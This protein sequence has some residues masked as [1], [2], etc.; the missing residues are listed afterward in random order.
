MQNDHGPA[1]PQ[2][3]SLIQPFA[4]IPRLVRGIGL[5]FVAAAALW[6]ATPAV[7]PASAAEGFGE[8]VVESAA[9]QPADGN[10]EAAAINEQVRPSAIRKRAFWAHRCRGAANGGQRCHIEHA[11]LDPKH[12]QI[13]RFAVADVG[14]VRRLVVFAPVGLKFP[15]ASM[16]ASTSWRRASCA[17]RPV[18]ARVARPNSPSTRRCRGNWPMAP[19]SPSCCR[20][21]A[22]A[23]AFRWPAHCRVSPSPIA[24]PL[25]VP[26]SALLS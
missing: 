2:F 22:A 3:A 23:G 26:P 15:T 18:T 9:D 5:M 21:A 11:V 25:A 16:S 14:G 1:A 10:G 7:P 6:A 24:A 12:R 8:T 4:T 13:V 17:S 20:T 19:A